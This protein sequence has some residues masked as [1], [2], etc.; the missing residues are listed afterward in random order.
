MLKTFLTSLALLAF[1]IAS[2]AQSGEDLVQ[3]EVR[4][5]W[6]TADGSHIAALHLQL[7]PGWKTYWRAPGD[8]GIPPELRLTTGTGVVSAR[9]HWP[10][11]RV[12]DQNGMYSIGY[13][14][15][16]VFPLTLTTEP[17]Q[18]V[19][20]QGS[21]FI[22][23]CEEI[24]IPVTLNFDTLL[25]VTGEHDQMI[26]AALD[27]TPIPAQQAGVGRVA[28]AVTPISDGL[29]M[30]AIIPLPQ[31]DGSEFVA[32]ETG[33][34]TIWVSE[35]QVRLDGAN[36]SATVDLVPPYGQTITLDRS[37]LRFTI[38]AEGR[39]VDIRGCDAG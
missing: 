11:P 38:L 28:C 35:A 8:G 3:L 27:D 16:V 5:G 39:A 18:D 32:V 22:G 24:C 17:D 14:N 30:T 23:V 15:D 34:P 31:A 4:T 29:Q 26:Q 2:F 37:A 10:T 12:F 7:E 1:P 9:P 25:P 20:L 19:R 6:R 36:L 21:L 13:Y 33:D